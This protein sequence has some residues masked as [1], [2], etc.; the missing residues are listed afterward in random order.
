M[1]GVTGVDLGIFSWVDD[2]PTGFTPT[3]IPPFLWNL[4]DKINSF[5]LRF[6]CKS[7]HLPPTSAQFCHW[8]GLCLTK[9]HWYWEI[10]HFL[11]CRNSN[12][13]F[14]IM[15]PYFW[16]HDSNYFIIIK[17]WS[18]LFKI[19]SNLNCESNRIAIRSLDLHNSFS[20][21]AIRSFD[22]NSFLR[23]TQCNPKER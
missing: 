4:Y 15:L 6:D 16:Y 18:Y 11:R 20:R 1:G 22:C 3:T 10:M 9:L 12:E 7:P 23:L 8:G 2:A 13:S 21:T 14:S 5:C 17:I 19:F